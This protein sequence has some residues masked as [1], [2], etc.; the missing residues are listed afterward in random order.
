MWV[1]ALALGAL[2]MA[3][4]AAG[5]LAAGASPASAPAT[6]TP[7]PP[8][9]PAQPPPP[10]APDPSA[11]SATPAPATHATNSL[12][13]REPSGYWT[14]P[15]NS[16]VPVTLQGG[17]VI[18]NARGLHALLQQQTSAILVDVS[19]AP[20]R[21]D[22]LAPGAPWLPVPHKA[23]PNSLWIPGVG[24]GEVPASLEQYFRQKLATATG[25]DLTRPVVFYCHRSCWLSWNAAKRAIGY[26]YSHVYWFRD[27]VEGW[28]AAG[29]PT[30]VIEP[31]S[32]PPA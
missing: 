3:A 8:A 7:T 14:G 29:Y 21:P 30:A 32:E 9:S 1:V 11:D 19:N 17:K 31:Q 20:R 26:G 12:A 2:G 28:K 15:T 13:A 5:A 23:I 6:D 10:P 18:S 25:N 22:N 4:L 16:P 24:T 27:G